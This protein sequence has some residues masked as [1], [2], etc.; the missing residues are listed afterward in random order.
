MRLAMAGVMALAAMTGLTAIAVS[1]GRVLAAGQAA[2]PERPVPEWLRVA[3]MYAP[4]SSAPNNVLIDVPANNTVYPPDMTA[5]QI[6]W[7]DFN[8]AA[9]VW[10]VEIVFGHG[11]PIRAWTNGEKLQI[12]ELDT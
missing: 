10:R 8:Q 12:G 2:T 4:A 5:P 1:S 3:S 11:R 6:A 9:T 7:R